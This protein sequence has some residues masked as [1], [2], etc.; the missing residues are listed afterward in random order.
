[1]RSFLSY[2][3]RRGDRRREL[4]RRI[5]YKNGVFVNG[6]AD[7]LFFDKPDSIDVPNPLNIDG[8]PCKYIH[9]SFGENC[10]RLRKARAEICICDQSCPATDKPVCGSDGI[11]YNNSCWLNL[12]MCELQIKIAI[13]KGGKCEDSNL[14]EH[15]AKS[16][17]KRRI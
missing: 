17:V 2:S 10:V 6:L 4:V 1:M 9:C 11:T 13:A 5:L 16:S 14:E 15:V 8:Q 7:D 3:T 12:T